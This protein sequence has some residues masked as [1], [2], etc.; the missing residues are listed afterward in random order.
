MRTWLRTNRIYLIYLYFLVVIG[1]LFVLTLGNTDNKGNFNQILD[2]SSGWDSFVTNDNELHLQRVIDESLEN[3]GLSFYTYN[4]YV[5]AKIDNEVFYEYN[6]KLFLTNTPGSGYRFLH[7]RGGAMGSNL[8]IIIKYQY[9][10][11]LTN[12]LSIK[13]GDDTLLRLY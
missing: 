4:A 12:N 8:E 11:M 5:T 3:K 6:P 1:T 13:V 10:H 7:I 9:S 2:Y